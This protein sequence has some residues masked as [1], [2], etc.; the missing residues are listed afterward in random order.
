V[1]GSFPAEGGHQRRIQ[2]EFPGKPGQSQRPQYDAVRRHDADPPR[3]PST[4]SADE[5]G[6]AG[7]LRPRFRR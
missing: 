6:Y 5:F 3:R 1:T 7:L 2:G 4:V